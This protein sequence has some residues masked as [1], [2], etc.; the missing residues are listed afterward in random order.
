[1]ESIKQLAIG[2]TMGMAINIALFAPMIWG[3]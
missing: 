2:L 3:L 1:M